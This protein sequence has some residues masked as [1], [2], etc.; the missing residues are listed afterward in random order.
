MVL[1]SEEKE[2]IVFGLQRCKNYITTGNF[3]LSTLDMKN[4]RKE[5]NIK[6]LNDDQYELITKLN[7][8]IKKIESVS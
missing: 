7:N 6:P 4:M 5:K 1:T 2:L 8:L 3:L